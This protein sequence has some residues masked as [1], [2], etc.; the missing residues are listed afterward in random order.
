MVL[1]GWWLA[2]HQ[3]ACWWLA[4]N[5][6]AGWFFANH[7]PWT[8]N[9]TLVAFRG[10]GHPNTIFKQKQQNSLEHSTKSETRD[11]KTRTPAPFCFEK[12]NILEGNCVFFV[13]PFAPAAGAPPRALYAPPEPP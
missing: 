5:Q 3:P 2:N 11:L 13:V 12:V 9:P 6:P 4:N 10:P 7:Q 1:A 8:P